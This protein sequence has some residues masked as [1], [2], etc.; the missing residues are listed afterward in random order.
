MYHNLNHWSQDCLNPIRDGVGD[1]AG[2]IN[3]RPFLPTKNNHIGTADFLCHGACSIVIICPVP[4]SQNFTPCQL[5]HIKPFKQTKK[6]F[7]R[8]EYV[9][10]A[11]V[12]LN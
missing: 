9:N 4:E 2:W 12:N 10:L 1:N 5:V 11:L 3:L 7:N 8:T 6:N